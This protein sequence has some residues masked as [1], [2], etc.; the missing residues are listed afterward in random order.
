MHFIKYA[1]P[2]FISKQLF[3]Q[4]GAYVTPSVKLK[5]S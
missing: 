4:L 1:S 2:D 3:F 5:I